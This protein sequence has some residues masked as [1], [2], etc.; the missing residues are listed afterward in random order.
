L[1]LFYMGEEIYFS[2]FIYSAV[3]TQRGRRAYLLLKTEVGN[4]GKGG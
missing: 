3:F 2:P 4:I 1:R